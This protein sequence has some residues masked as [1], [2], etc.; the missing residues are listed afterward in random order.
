MLGHLAITAP[1]IFRTTT[2]SLVQMDPAL[3]ESARSLGAGPVY[4][5]ATVTL[6]LILLRQVAE[7]E[8]RPLMEQVARGDEVA[9]EAWRQLVSL[10]H[11]YD[12]IPQVVRRADEFAET[13][14][15]QLRHFPESRERDALTGLADF[16]LARDR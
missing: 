4:L 10:L 5:F 7:A 16:V 13:A 1:Y 15:L 3:V 11:E 6:P 8:A 9:D 14:R 12:V 2:A